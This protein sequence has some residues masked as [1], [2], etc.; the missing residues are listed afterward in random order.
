MV[1]FGL[2]ELVS[3]KI[4]IFLGSALR[5]VDLVFKPSDLLTYRELLTAL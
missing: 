4:R 2:R 5:K 3:R 1:G